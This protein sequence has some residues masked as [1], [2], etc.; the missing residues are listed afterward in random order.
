M[1]VQ[2]PRSFRTQTASESHFR[3]SAS[4]TGCDLPRAGPAEG[5][6]DYQ[7]SSD[8]GPCAYMHRHSPQA[9]GGIG[10]R[11]S[12]RKECD[13]HRSPERQGA[14]LYGRIRLDVGLN[15]AVL[16]FAVAAAVLTGL[17]FG[18]APAL[19]STSAGGATALRT[20]SSAGQARGR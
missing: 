12:Q 16:E 19:R 5:M 13:R 8:A 10:D 20:A 14:Q 3:A 9:P 15:L 1:G 7:G 6:P 11:I 4:A 17:L 2:V 18:T